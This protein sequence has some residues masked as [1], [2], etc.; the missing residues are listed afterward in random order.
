VLGHPQL[1][2]RTA[3]MENLPTK[4]ETKTLSEVELKRILINPTPEYIIESHGKKNI[5]FEG[6][7]IEDEYIILDDSINLDIP[8]TFSKCIFRSENSV[9]IC[10]MVS[11]ESVIFENCLFED[12]MYIDS[13]IFK[14]VIFKGIEAQNISIKGGS[15]SKISISGNSISQFKISYA[16]YEQLIIGEFQYGECI[17]KLVIFVDNENSGDISVINQSFD[18]VSIIGTNKGRKIRFEKLKCDSFSFHNFKNEGE[19]YFNGIAP[20]G[21]D[22]SNKY[23]QI[24]NSNLSNTEFYRVCFPQYNELII[25]DSFI[26]DVI[27]IGCEWSNNIRAQYGPG[28][29][30]FED[31]LV[32]GRKYT[33]WE[34]KNIKEVTVHDKTR[35]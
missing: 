17:N 11:N 8:L 1:T 18:E 12:S 9:Y 30:E 28:Y 34:Y 23:F 33:L 24:I 5:L 16:K 7:I 13:G 19:L 2:L 35:K 32:S 29:R 21:I 26:T 3:D 10:G 6:Y 14:D 27:F 4:P 22:N 31:S 25:I 20:K 15:F